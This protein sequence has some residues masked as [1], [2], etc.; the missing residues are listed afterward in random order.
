MLNVNIQSWV[1]KHIAFENN[2]I[3]TIFAS[4][5]ARNKD[6]ETY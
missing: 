2:L 1:I 5:I 3:S 4:R 6:Y